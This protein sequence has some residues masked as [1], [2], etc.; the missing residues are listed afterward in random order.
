M[1]TNCYSQAFCQRTKGSAASLIFLLL[2]A[3][4]RNNHHKCIRPLSQ[5]SFVGLYNTVDSRISIRML[6]SS[7]NTEKYIELESRAEI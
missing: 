7:K 5:E 6:I 4:L 1:S 2:E 3:Y